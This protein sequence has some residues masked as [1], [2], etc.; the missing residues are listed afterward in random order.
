MFMRYYLIVE[1]GLDSIMKVPVE[2][3]GIFL[4]FY[5]E[6]IIFGSNTLLG[7]SIQIQE[8]APIFDRLLS[9]SDGLGVLNN[10]EYSDN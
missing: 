5:M 9:V 1:D 2:S 3:V 6:K 4:D 8:S 10:C 7:L